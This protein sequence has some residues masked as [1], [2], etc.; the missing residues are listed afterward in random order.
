M[1]NGTIIRREGKR[2]TSYLLKY[3]GP[4]DPATGRRH[5]LYKTVRGS[6]RDAQRELRRLLGQLDD[7]TH[8]DPHKLTVAEWLTSW[9]RDHAS[10]AIGAKSR[11]R[12]GDMINLHVIPRI[13]AGPLIKLTPPTIQRLYSDLLTSGR[14][15]RLT[16]ADG[17]AQPAGLA[18]A[19]VLYVHRVLH[20]ALSTAVRQRLL[21]RNP[22]EDVTPPRPA[23]LRSSGVDGDGTEKMRALE[24][25][26]LDTL[27][28]AFRGSSLFPIVA[29]AAGT[30]MRR[31][32]VLALRWSDVDL[33]RATIRVARSVEDTKAEGIRF[34]APKTK[35]SRRTIGIDP[36][37]VAL[38]R[39][40]W[41][42]QAEEALKLGIRLA[43]DHLVFPKSPVALTT[44]RPPRYV[45]HDFVARAAKAGFAGL[46]FHDLR[47]TH[48]TLLLIGGVPI[49]AVA[50]RLGHS[51]PV[52]TLTVYGHVLRRAEDQ[53]V[54]VA[55]SLL[56]TALQDA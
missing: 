41:R 18:P 22:A 27:L 1:S 20:L 38:L 4:R 34:K 39:A 8:V 17:P 55:G 42:R 12:Y 5:Q 33:D 36:G 56:A 3:D 13:G 40:E 37:L 35:Q 45:T 30:G 49:N 48:A 25:D 6:L 14:R 26:Q 28:C 47:H 9:L 10:T 32:E 29:V 2:G 31:G 43:P 46:R 51:S 11:E 44:P 54:A 7:G 23:A 15:P 19:T 50:Q 16:A 21:P 52:V 24:R 53:A